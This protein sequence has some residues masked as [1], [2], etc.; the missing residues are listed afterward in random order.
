MT[1]AMQLTR[2]QEALFFAVECRICEMKTHLSSIV[3]FVLLCG[4]LPCI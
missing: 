3:W 4:F 1:T 2:V